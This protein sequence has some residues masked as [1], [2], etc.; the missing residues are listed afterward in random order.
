M[1]AIVSSVAAGRETSSALR[2]WLLP[3]PYVSSV[4]PAGPPA[5]QNEQTEGLFV[6]PSSPGGVVRAM[7]SDCAPRGQ[8]LRHAGVMPTMTR[9]EAVDFLAGGTRTGHLA[10]A[11]PQ[12][13]PHLAPVWFVVDGDDLVFTTDRDSIKG[14]HLRANP[15]G[16]L[17][18]DV[19]EYPYHFVVVRG[20]AAAEE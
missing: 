3:H 13:P 18:V 4:R 7:L 20:P 15:R 14:R 17:T 10:T 12:G 19:A 9:T 5:R 8:D 1:Y 6:R 11:P 2:G 16:A